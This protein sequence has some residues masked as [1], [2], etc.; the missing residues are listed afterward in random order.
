MLIMKTLNKILTISVLASVYTMG[1]MGAVEA[2]D[3][4]ILDPNQSLDGANLD[5]VTI[6]HNT[7]YK[8]LKNGS[9]TNSIISGDKARLIMMN[10]TGENLVLGNESG[11]KGQLELQESKWPGQDKNGISSV[12][13][14]TAYNDSAITLYEKSHIED[15]L[16]INN[17]QKNGSLTL[18]DNST[19]ANVTIKGSYYINVQLYDKS[20]LTDIDYIGDNGSLSI[21]N[22]AKVTSSEGKRNTFKNVEVE[23]Y[24]NATLENSDFG[25]TS[26][27]TSQDT[28]NRVAKTKIH[29]LTINDNSE[30]RTT[31]DNY[32]E[33]SNLTANDSA[34]IY[35]D[36]I[37][38]FSNITLNDNTKLSTAT[39]HNGKINNITVKSAA[40]VL[41][42]GNDQYSNIILRDKAMMI[43]CKNSVSVNNFTI[44][45]NSNLYFSS[46]GNDFV[47]DYAIT[48]TF[49]AD[50][51]KVS[52]FRNGNDESHYNQKTLTIDKLVNNDPA[53]TT[54]FVLRTDLDGE[55]IV[56]SVH[57]KEANEGGK[58]AVS[59]L[60]KSK[61]LNQE[62]GNNKK[63]LVVKDDSKNVEVVGNKIDNGGLW[64]IIPTIEN[65]LLVGGTED[66]WYLTNIQKE[67]NDNT[68]TILDGFA[69]DY[70]LWLTANDTLRK[71]LGDIR[72]GITQDDGVWVRTYHGKLKGEGYKNNYHIYQLGYDKT[73]GQY[74]EGFF[75]E[76]S[77]G[78]L[79]FNAG[80]GENDYNALGLYS[81]W[82]GDKGHY[83]DI[84]LRAGRLGHEMNTY[85]EFADSSDY[86]NAAYSIS[87]EY[88]KQ[89]NY[90]NG[91]FVTPQAQLTLGR[92]EGI[93]FT[94]ANG[95][96][97]DVGG[98]TSAIGRIG[99][100]AG[101]QLG[102]KGSYYVK[103][104]AFHEFDGERNVSMLAANGDCLN[105]GYDYSDTW[106]EIG[107]GAQ[108]KTSDNTYFYCD[109]ERSLG[110]S[111]TEKVW[112]FN[113]GFRW[114]F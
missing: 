112:Q 33:V 12:K 15:V 47:N 44:Q 107:V 89:K 88:G 42:M 14:I 41:A 45:D 48:G 10:S 109:A 23:L 34:E 79:S 99:V 72:N 30:L 51:G 96:K 49:T 21:Q 87:F 5:N 114:E 17:S 26:I 6:N 86:H 38:D 105:E 11:E 55:N 43:V 46:M 70:S 80:S 106:Y 73:R 7:Y 25:G 74:T 3:A 100:E 110:G 40:K 97:V 36:G 92:I 32:S 71:R 60:D 78:N 95:T 63:V 20:V 52:W 37:D 108:V 69:S 111:D 101:R 31:S 61:V 82:L 58:I 57:I 13:G 102:D 84:V 24:D 68:N 19:A 113:A 98:L 39:E 27:I 28:D 65:G 64:N 81:T 50:G 9:I 94:T 8:P 54:E 85:G 77:E 76:R 4:N 104:G 56:E 83:T 35:A 53:K 67:N 66:E 2:A 59:V 75:L 22:D 103:L 29:N 91:W 93:D 1:F 16:M 90:D 18:R 62:A